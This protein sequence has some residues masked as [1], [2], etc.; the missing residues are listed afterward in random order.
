VAWPFL[1]FWKKFI[2]HR[3][4]FFPQQSWLRTIPAAEGNSQIAAVSPLLFAVLKHT[5][6]PQHHQSAA[7]RRVTTLM[8]KIIKFGDVVN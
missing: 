8:R 1:L 3:Y 4:L 2:S 5:K 6:A 7:R